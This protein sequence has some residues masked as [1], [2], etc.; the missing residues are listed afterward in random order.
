MSPL[1]RLGLPISIVLARRA[2]H[3]QWPGEQVTP[4]A[5]RPWRRPIASSGKIHGDEL[6][7]RDTPPPDWCRLSWSS[8]WRQQ[9]IISVSIRFSRRHVDK[10]N[11]PTG[12]VFYVQQQTG[13]RADSR[14][15]VSTVTW[16]LSRPRWTDI[17]LVFRTR[18]KWPSYVKFPKTK[19]PPGQLR[20]LGCTLL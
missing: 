17:R 12:L 10:Q 3:W 14:A 9:D 8:R 6:T 19:W 7:D 4:V 16:L 18:L 1:T 20:A 13:T 2:S 5:S 11:T 15:P